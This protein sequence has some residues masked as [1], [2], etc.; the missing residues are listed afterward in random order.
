MQSYLF[1]FFALCGYLCIKENFSYSHP[2]NQLCGSMKNRN[3]ATVCSISSSNGGQV[4]QRKTIKLSPKSQKSMDFIS[5][6][7][8]TQKQVVKGLQ[9]SDTSKSRNQLSS[10]AHSLNH[11]KEKESKSILWNQWISTTSLY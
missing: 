6:P 4:Y 5:K 1:S 3:S 7:C 9:P 11:K 2:A 10:S 8:L